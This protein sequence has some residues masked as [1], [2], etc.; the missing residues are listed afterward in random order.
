[1]TII[2][3]SFG[4]FPITTTEPMVERRSIQQYPNAQEDLKIRILLMIL[5]NSGSGILPSAG[6][7]LPIPV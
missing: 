7:R 1:M 5:N 6:Y 3:R 2:L 4:D